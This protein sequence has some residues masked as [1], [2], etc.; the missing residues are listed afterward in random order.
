MNAP[1][2]P[3]KLAAVVLRVLNGRLEGAEHRLHP[4][5]FVRVGHGFDHDIVLRDPSTRGLSLE[6]HLGDELAT[7]RV[8][9]GQVGLL[10]RPVAA[11]EETALPAY[12]PMTLGGFAV[13]IGDPASERWEE[14]ARLSTTIAP[15]GEAAVPVESQR[16]ALTERVATRFYPMRD[17]LSIER[18]W[19]VYAVVAAALLLLVALAGP[20]VRWIGGQFHN[21]DA[22]RAVLAASGFSALKVSDSPSGLIITGIVKDDAELARLRMVVAERIGAATIDVDSM[23]ALAAS[24]TDLLRTQGIDGEARPMRGNSLLVT[25]EYLPGD[26]Q[27][28]L[29]KLIQADV[30]GVTRVAFTTDNARGDRD[31]QY[32]FSGSEYG[33]ATFVDGSPGYITTA[34]GTRWFAGAQVPTGHKIIAIGNGRVSFERDGRVEE[35]ILGNG[36]PPAPGVASETGGTAKQGTQS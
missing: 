25:A 14:T 20:T 35:L 21:P 36:T 18:R 32:F 2:A 22:D 30:P 5:K 33:L 16:A 3:L 6:L 12:V 8:I 9:A 4:G 15:A 23:Q 7:I 11:G 28:E 31:L 19:P 34:D 24:A 10:G 1:F 29:A 13:A 27:T 26:R 17:A